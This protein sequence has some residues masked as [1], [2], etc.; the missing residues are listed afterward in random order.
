MKGRLAAFHD[1]LDGLSDPRDVDRTLANN[2]SARLVTGHPIITPRHEFRVPVYHQ[3][4]VVARKNQLAILLR[5]PN[6]SDYFRLYPNFPNGV[7][8]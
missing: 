4:G 7:S 2:G 6:P 1:F 8:T 5:L 3:I